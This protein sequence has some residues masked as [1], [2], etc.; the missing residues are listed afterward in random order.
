MAAS[1]DQTSKKY[2][3][4]KPDE[5][6]LIGLIRFLISGNIESKQFIECLRV[7]KTSLKHRVYIFFSIF[8]QNVLQ[9]AAKPLSVFGSIFE[10]WLNLLACNGNFCL[11][12][13]NLL[14]GKVVVPAEGS[15]DFMSFLG[16]FDRRVELDKNI[17]PGDKKYFAE[18]SVMASKI[19][20]ENK[21]FIKAVV[22]DKWKMELIGEYDFWNEYQQ[23]YSTQGLIIHDKTAN[24]DMIIV[25]FRGTE[26]FNA[27]DWRTDFDLSWHKFQSMGKVH[28]GFIKAL[29]L[30]NDQSWPPTIDHDNKKPI[31]Y[32]T[33]KEKLRKL[34]H[35]HSRTKFILT[36]HSLGGALA[37]LFPAVLAL[38]DET[39][40][41]ERLEAIYTFGQPRVGDVKFGD[42][43]KEQLKSYDI[44]YYR[45]VY[46]HDI[47]PRLPYDDD[48]TLLFRH[49]GTC[50][51]YNSLY[52]GKIFPQEPH[53]NYFSIRA[54]ITKRL[55]A[56]WELVRSF[57]LPHL[58]GPEYREGLLL[59]VCRLFGL[60]VPG[61][62]AHGIQEYINAVRLGTAEFWRCKEGI[63]GGANKCFCSQ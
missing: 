50:L 51:F 37:I 19:A 59:L 49:F 56:L 38:H 8:I 30:Q 52:E 18:L 6:S 44:K 39:C 36:G 16:H 60:L 57:L 42:F 62:P 7:K 23:K 43:V 14:R 55:D 27:D 25:A 3:V 15:A 1:N 28:S 10:L 53:R 54:F 13:L 26:L 17:K 34:L 46:N 31:A 33:I 4:L 47:V 11:F 20:Y 45:F 40:I 29:G 21:A 32:Y 48:T 9:F 58:Y 12:L 41:L 5:A 35:P 63:T 22:E 2:M 61:F 24:P